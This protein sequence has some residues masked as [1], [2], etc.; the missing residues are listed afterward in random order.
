MAK[1]LKSILLVDDDDTTNFLHQLAI[2]KSEATEHIEVAETVDDAIAYLSEQNTET[3]PDLIFLDLNLP[4]LSG[5][6][7][8]E[9]YQTLSRRSNRSSVIVVLTASVNRDDEFLALKTIG[10]N[11]FRVKPLTKD[12]LDE[13]LETYF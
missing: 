5:W 7:F 13:I 9:E 6:D 10:I 11:N 8:M 4:G 12:M 3:W 1:K 2:Q